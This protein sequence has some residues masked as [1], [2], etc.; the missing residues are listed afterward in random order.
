[1]PQAPMPQ[2]PD[3]RSLA[4]AQEPTMRPVAMD[5]NL[6]AML[7]G[8]PV[9]HPSAQ[10]YRGPV[11]QNGKPIDLGPPP[12]VPSIKRTGVRKTRSKLQVMMWIL[13]GIVVIGGGV[14]AGFQIRAI[15]LKKHVAVAR[16]QAMELEKSENNEG[17]DD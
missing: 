11:E 7:A 2:A 8:M 6:Q 16:S 15:R 9:E 10:I 13:I 4:A 5:P 3:P 12:S 14:F 17:W 1:M